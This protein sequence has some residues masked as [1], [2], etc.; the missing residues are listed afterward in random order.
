MEGNIQLA[1]GKGDAG[2]VA[3]FGEFAAMMS[4]RFVLAKMASG[5]ERPG[6]FEFGPFR[7]ADAWSQARARTSDTDGG[8]AALV[9]DRVERISASTGWVLP[10]TAG[11]TTGTDGP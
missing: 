4:F 1:E 7:A 6:P 8:Y 9:N 3:E 11:T 10:T 5:I 2:V